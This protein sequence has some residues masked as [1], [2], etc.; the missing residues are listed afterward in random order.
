MINIIPFG[1]TYMLNNKMNKITRTALLTLFGSIVS[2]K[3]PLNVFDEATVQL[4]TGKMFFEES[5]NIFSIDTSSKL[6]S[7]ICPS[8]GLELKKSIFSNRLYL[9]LDAKKY[10]ASNNQQIDFYLNH[11]FVS[12]HREKIFYDNYTAS[13]MYTAHKNYNIAIGIGLNYGLSGYYTDAGTKSK[14]K[15]A[16]FPLYS[17]QVG[18]LKK[19]NHIFSYKLGS[20]ILDKESSQEATIESGTYR[21]VH[22]KYI[23]SRSKNMCHG[24]KAGYSQWNALY[25]LG[26]ST[27]K[28][29]NSD[30]YFSYELS[31]I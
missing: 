12:S 9:D 26:A 21:D 22:Y 27:S 7:S 19:Q 14:N 17:L 23:F 20:I 30:T 13:L 16:A 24:L 3:T 10:F 18:D 28:I 1:E 5:S 11:D 25:D 8:L 4:G 15:H 6:H 31:F 2:A 29:K